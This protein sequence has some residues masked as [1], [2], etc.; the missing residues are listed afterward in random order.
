MEKK[1]LD[2][3]LGKKVYDTRLRPPGQ[4]TSSGDHANDGDTDTGATLVHVNIFVRDFSAI[5]DVG[6][7]CGHNNIKQIRNLNFTL[8]RSMI[9]Q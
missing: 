6:M 1:I 4:N 7:V 2:E 3:I 8:D 9:S 5:S